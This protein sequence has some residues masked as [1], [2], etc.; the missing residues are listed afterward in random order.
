MLKEIAAHRTQEES[1]IAAL[2]DV[3]ESERAAIYA[4]NAKVAAAIVPTDKQI[5]LNVGGVYFDTSQR[6]LISARG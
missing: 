1:E 6:T 4:Q 2:R 5:K 3:A